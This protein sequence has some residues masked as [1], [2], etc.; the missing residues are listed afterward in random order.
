VILAARDMYGATQRLLDAFFVPRGTRV[1]TCDMTDHAAVERALADLQPEVV[2]VEQL[3]NPLL[4]ILDIA[5]LAQRCKAAGARLVVD[6]TI[7]T[8][9]LQRPLVLGADLVV[10]SATKYIGGHGDVAGGVVV[11]RAGLL[12]DTL[13]AQANLLGAN[14]SPFA[15]QQLLRGLKTL[16]LRFERQ[17]ANAAQV[18]AWLAQHPAVQRVYYP[19]L[20]G[21]P[22]HSLAQQ[23]FGG[24]FGALVTFDMRQGERAALSRF[25]SALRLILPA[26]T[27][28]DLY[29]LASVPAL[30]SHR[31]LSPEERAARG[32]SEGTVRLS[33]GIEAVADLLADLDGA[34]AA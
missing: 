33:I 26:T 19:G 24:K 12:R 4:H 25:F 7:A 21:H 13:R 27:L 28:G 1:A 6:N 32:I 10:H 30:A 3:T 5:W 14:L 20:P 11:A 8:P 22:R 16:A 29:T 18:A 34:L 2:L 17:C 31:E 9:L 23:A 15:A